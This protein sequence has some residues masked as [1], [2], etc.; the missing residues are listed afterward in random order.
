MPSR[1]SD[2]ID[3]RGVMTT[4]PRPGG[5]TR[6]TRFRV[7]VRIFGLGRI[8][9]SFVERSTRERYAASGEFANEFLRTHG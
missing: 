4:E 1:A 7:D 3:I 6:V 5:C 2:K 9:E 8:V